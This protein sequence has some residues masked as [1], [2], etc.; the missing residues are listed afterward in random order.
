MLLRW[1]W[2]MGL[3]RELLEVLACPRCKG[4]VEDRDQWVVCIRCAL[5]YPV[6]DGIAVMLPERAVALK[7]LKGA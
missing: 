2:L 6:E 3:D 4:P 7:E 1:R 5:A